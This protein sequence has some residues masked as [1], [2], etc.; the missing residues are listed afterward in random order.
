MINEKVCKNMEDCDLTLKT[1]CFNL[2]D[3]LECG[4]CFRWN[5]V[6]VPTEN[7][8]VSEYVGILSDRVIRI[9]QED[10]NIYVW[11]NNKENLEETINYYFDLYNSYEKIENRISK[12]DDNVKKAVEHSTR[13][14]HIKSRK[15]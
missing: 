13:H 12:I 2:K 7:R 1:E 9:R 4:Q 3:T 11:S 6:D 10:K 15:I 5:R 8:D 14:T